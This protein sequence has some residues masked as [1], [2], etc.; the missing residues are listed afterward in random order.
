MG[1]HNRVNTVLANMTT[2]RRGQPNNAGGFDNKTEGSRYCIGKP[3]QPVN[4]V[5]L[6]IA[7]LQQ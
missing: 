2:R 6:F 3:T 7:A 5:L 4:T 1:N